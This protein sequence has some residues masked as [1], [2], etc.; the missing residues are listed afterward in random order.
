MKTK[1][2]PHKLSERI[3][4]K[5]Q[6]ELKNGYVLS[7]ETLRQ[8]LLMEELDTMYEILY[9]LVDDFGRHVYTE[10]KKGHKHG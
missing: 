5:V 1:L 7:V 4:E 9:H 8:R 3:E 10:S 6:E 2:E